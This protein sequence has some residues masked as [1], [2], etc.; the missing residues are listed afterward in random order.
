MA[1]T[2]LDGAD[3]GWQVNTRKR[4]NGRQAR[5]ATHGSSRPAVEDTAPRIVTRAPRDLLVTQS[6]TGQK[7][8]P[9]PQLSQQP[10]LKQLPPSDAT[11]RPTIHLSE[12]QFNPPLLFSNAASSNSVIVAARKDPRVYNIDSFAKYMNP[13]KISALAE[14][15]TPGKD[16]MAKASFF[17]VERRVLT[18]KVPMFLVRS[19]RDTSQQLVMVRNGKDIVPFSE[20]LETLPAPLPALRH[21][22]LWFQSTLE[23]WCSTPFP[24][25]TLGF[26]KV[27]QARQRALYGW[28]ERY[29]GLDFSACP[30]RKAIIDYIMCFA[31]KYIKHIPH[32]SLT[33]YVKESTR[34]RWL[35]ALRTRSSREQLETTINERIEK[36][37]R[38]PLSKLP[39]ECYCPQSC[40][41]THLESAVHRYHENLTRKM[42]DIQ[43]A[44]QKYRFDHDD[45]YVPT[46]VEKAVA[47]SSETREVRHD[48]PYAWDQDVVVRD[49]EVEEVIEQ[50]SAA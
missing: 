21:L 30:C 36:I 40:D 34:D 48:D 27:H 7:P 39:P 9:S 46:R 49:D 13:L 22:E 43:K 11:D 44:I 14:E 19:G 41:Y 1:Q 16:W 45:S 33:G 6:R 25:D 50:E 24:H 17:A 18:A 28:D 5:V 10:A 12:Q 3:D 15:A 4:A 38:I 26:P 47:Q 23:R 20:W 29:K 8:T 31:Y 42:D 2:A 32:V 35:V 37:K